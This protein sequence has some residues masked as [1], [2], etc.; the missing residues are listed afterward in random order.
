[1]DAL[2]YQYTWLR[3]FSFMVDPLSSSFDNERVTAIVYC[4]DKNLRYRKV[5]G[6][7]VVND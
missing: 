7:E 3:D 1:M 4:Y 2:L 6:Y 5:K